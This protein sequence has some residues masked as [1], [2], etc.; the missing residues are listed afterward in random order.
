MSNPASP[1]SV[2]PAAVLSLIGNTPMLPLRFEPEGLTIHAK[3]EVLN[4]S[5]SVKDRFA[6]H[7][8]PRVDPDTARNPATFGANVRANPRAGR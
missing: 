5:G 6:K 2:R 1:N 3:C 4:P 8:V 7:V